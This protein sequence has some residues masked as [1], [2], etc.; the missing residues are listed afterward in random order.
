MYLTLYLLPH[1]VCSNG[2]RVF[3]QRDILQKFT[4]QVVKKVKK[5]KI[6]DPLL[7][8]TR[9]GA[10]IN[11]PQLD[12]VFAFIKGAKEQGA[13]VLTG[14]EPYVPEDPKLKAG[15]FMTPCVL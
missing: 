3:V 5:I 9:M 1:Q 10:L 12:K 15:F 8:D 2:T 14:G 7:E 4:D 6:G 13:K 11:R